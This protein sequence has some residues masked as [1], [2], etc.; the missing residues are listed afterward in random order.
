MAPRILLVSLAIL[1]PLSVFSLVWGTLES[2]HPGLALPACRDGDATTTTTTTN[3]TTNATETVTETTNTTTAT[4]S[5][6]FQPGPGGPLALAAGAGGITLCLAVPLAFI[7]ARVS[8]P[9]S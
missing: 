7:A 9:K 5:C 1:A 6:V 8:K 2:F 3:T 4:P